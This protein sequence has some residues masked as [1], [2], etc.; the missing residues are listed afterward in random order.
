MVYQTNAIMTTNYPPIVNEYDYK[1]YHVT[2]NFKAD[3][4]YGRGSY[5]AMAYNTNGEVVKCAFAVK[6]LEDIDK[7]IQ[8]KI[9]SI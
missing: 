8:E 6:G 7:K 5:T 3:D 2:V 1:G 9:D 4:A